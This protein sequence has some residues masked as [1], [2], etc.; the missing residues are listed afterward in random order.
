M[1][2]KFGIAAVHWQKILS[3]FLP[4]KQIE[5]VVLFGS[6][7]MGNF[8]AGSDIDLCLKGDIDP[9]LIP[10]ILNDYELLF[11]PWKLDLVL[12]NQIQ[13]PDLKE[14]IQRVGVEV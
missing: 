12:W 10:K 11:L 8:R 9:D 7:A 4:C 6:R 3:L 13:N 2:D 1:S 5:S 14:H